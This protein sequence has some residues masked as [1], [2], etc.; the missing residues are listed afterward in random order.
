ML[1]RRAGAGLVVV[2]AGAG[3][4]GCGNPPAG[5]LAGKTPSQILSAALAA[6]RTEATV[7]FTLDVSGT[8]VQE[9]VV[10]NLGLLEGQEELTLGTQQVEAELVDQTT[11]LDATAG[12]LQ[13]D[14]GLPAA[15][16]AAYADRWISSTSSDPLY[17]HITQ[18]VT[19]NGVLSQITPS[20]RLRASRPGTLRG[21]VV[22]GV[23]GGLPGPPRAGTTGQAQL[24]VSTTAPDVPVGFTSEARASGQQLT[25]VGTFSDWGGALDLRPPPGAVPY[26]SLPRS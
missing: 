24:Y 2:L 11:Y 13:S 14:L 12:W 18:S 6:A 25:E 5:V 9:T 4:S 20:G 7:H 22:I 19:L 15:V 21:R 26:T 3:L 1:L 8:N 23:T 16:A 10:G 17:R